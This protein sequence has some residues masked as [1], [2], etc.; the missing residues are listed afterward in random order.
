M[1]ISSSDVPVCINTTVNVK[2]L[3]GCPVS[4]VN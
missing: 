2:D 1:R 4:K 3:P